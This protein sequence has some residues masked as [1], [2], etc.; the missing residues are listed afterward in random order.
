MSEENMM[1][2]VM[3]DMS[4]AT[5]QTSHITHHTDRHA[6]TP[7]LT[8]T[9]VHPTRDMTPHS[10]DT[11]SSRILAIQQEKERIKCFEF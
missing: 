11:I 3:C 8:V 7:H 1:K 4:H 9:T 5:L 2:Y 10:L 6:T